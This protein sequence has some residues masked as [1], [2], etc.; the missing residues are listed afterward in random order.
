[1]FLCSTGLWV[2]AIKVD[3]APFFNMILRNI[4]FI[5]LLEL[6]Q[7]I[8][9]SF[10]YNTLYLVFYL[11]LSNLVAQQLK[12]TWIGLVVKHL[13]R[14]KIV[15]SESLNKLWDINRLTWALDIVFRRNFCPLST[16][17]FLA[18]VRN[19]PIAMMKWYWKGLG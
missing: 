3:R 6:K 15:W 10:C 1:M 19:V 5:S 9:L 13:F 7:F 17:P 18:R 8:I 2:G 11:I 4:I 12:G 14:S 16:I